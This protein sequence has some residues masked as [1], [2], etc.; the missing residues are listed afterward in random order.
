MTTIQIKNMVCNRC[1]RVVQETLEKLGFTVLSIDLGHAEIAD[2]PSRLT[3][4]D[5]RTALQNEE[6]DLIDDKRQTL[7]EQTKALLISEIQHQVTEKK[8]AEN[9]SAFLERKLGYDYSY[10]SHLFSSSEGQTLEKYIIALKIEKVKEWLQYGE[11]TLS[12]IAFKLGY[13][14]SQH[15]STQFRQLTGLTP[16]QFRKTDNA[17]R[18]PLDRL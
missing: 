4:T 6:F 5:L 10:L 8:E 14:S 7:V 3:V 1:K 16:G 17:I 15:L 13:S 9:F 12:E 18:Q 11:M 2:W